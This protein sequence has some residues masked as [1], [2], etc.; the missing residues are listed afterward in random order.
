M[1]GFTP[2]IEDADTRHEVSASEPTASL[3]SQQPAA[4]LSRHSPGGQ[5]APILEREP[6]VRWWCCDE[7]RLRAPIKQRA[8]KGS[9]SR[10]SR[11][12][13][14]ASCGTTLEQVADL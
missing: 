10:H 6:I 13:A 9:A 11:M 1:G 8:S 12:R 2:W 14:L 3:P 5:P 4:Q 7:S